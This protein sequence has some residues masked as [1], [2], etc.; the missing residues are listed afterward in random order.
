MTFR[1]V[2]DGDVRTGP[3][4]SLPDRFP[5]ETLVRAVVDDGSVATVRVDCPRPAR[6]YGFVSPLRAAMAF[7]RRG[8]LAELARSEGHEAPQSDEI[9]RLRESLL[10][11]TAPDVSLA[12]ARRRVVEAGED[13]VRLRESVAAARGRLGTL[14]ELGRPEEEAAAALEDEIARLTEA[15]T[16][17][18]AAE[19]RLRR[20]ERD[21][22]R[23]RDER[24]RRFSLEDR[25]ANR[26]REARSWL[27][28]RVYERFAA[29]TARLAGETD[30]DADAGEEPG[31][32]EGD[33][34]TAAAAVVRTA[35]FEAPILVATD[36]FGDAERTSCLLEAPVIRR[37]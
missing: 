13:E 10:D 36:R 31:D 27:A 19:E 11:S 8:A 14:R 16:E 23:E 35:N 5:T 4:V 25:L 15:E 21:V 24:E 9:A 1:L 32:Y 12:N 6:L 28:S 37:P 18:M 7:D 2:V 26:R 34:L 29:A 3:A 20:L 22:R 17:R 33:T 30:V